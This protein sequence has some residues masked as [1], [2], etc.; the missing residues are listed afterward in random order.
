MTEMD[1]ERMKQRPKTHLLHQILEGC[2]REHLQRAL[3]CKKQQIY[4]SPLNTPSLPIS[5]SE[6]RK[7]FL[8]E[9]VVC[10]DRV[11][12][13]LQALEESEGG[14]RDTEYMGVAL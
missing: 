14:S 11:A 12:N 10:G 7:C 1:C 6:S 8:E 3:N 9:L 5:V 13:D 4:Q 2:R